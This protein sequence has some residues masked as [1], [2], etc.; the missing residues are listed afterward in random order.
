[1]QSRCSLWYRLGVVLA[2]LVACSVTGCCRSAD[3][4]QASVTWPPAFSPG[5]DLKVPMPDGTRLMTDVYAPNGQGPWPIIL[6]RTP[7]DPS[8]L[9]YTENAKDFNAAGVVYVVQSARGQFGSEGHPD[10]FAHDRQD[11]RDMI[12]LLA[13]QSWSNGKIGIMGHSAPGIESYL[14]LPNV[15]GRPADL[16]CAWIEMATPDLQKTAFQDGVFRKKLSENWLRDNNMA[17]LI[18]DVIANATN[19]SWW[20]PRRITQDYDKIDVPTVHLTG[21]FDIFTNEQIDAFIGAHQAGAPSQYLIIGPWTHDAIDLRTQGELTFPPSADLQTDALFQQFMA[22]FL[23]GEGDLRGWPTVR[24]YTMG[25]VDEPAAPGNEWRAA[26]QWPP[27]TPNPMPL[28]LRVGGSL[29]AIPPEAGEQARQYS[30]DPDSPAPTVGGNN[31]FLPRGPRDQSVLEARSDILTYTTALLPNPLEVTGKV[32]GKIHLQ[33]NRPDTDLIV[34]LCDVYPDSRSIPVT[35]GA[36]RLRFRNPSGPVVG[37]LMTPGQ[38]YE[39]ELA[40]WP[41]SIIFNAGHRLRVD[42]TSSSDPRFDPN[43]N[44]GDALRANRTTAVATVTILH[45]Q[46]HPSRIILP[47][48]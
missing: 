36:L 34:R 11:A 7:Y 6:L 15:D 10:F 32:V 27:F 43:P 23:L 42:V 22:R 14:A 45:D 16:S 33:C 38:T 41:T 4:Q 37:V 8:K 47:T 44:T 48:P 17:A 18:P 24:Y 3:S 13:A 19:A 25:D 21:W 26:D 2:L 1:M 9:T 31:L 12:T 28:Y 40:L 20:T 30:Y 29:S 35:E 39:I 46:A 5:L